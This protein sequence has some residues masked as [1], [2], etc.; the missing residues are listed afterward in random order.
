R[1]EELCLLLT[2]EPRGF[3]IDCA[4]TETDVGQSLLAGEQ[5]GE[6]L[7]LDEPPLD[8]DLAEAAPGPNALF[9][10]VLDHLRGQ[11][12]RPEDQRAERRIRSF[13]QWSAHLPQFSP[14]F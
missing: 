6:G 1:T 7:F 13:S 4:L 10:G 5:A 12:S 11:E 9:E 2:E 14:A 8:E 3:R